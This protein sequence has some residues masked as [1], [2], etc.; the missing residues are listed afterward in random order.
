[1]SKSAK[2]SRRQQ[3]IMELI[4]ERGEV[5]VETLAIALRV[6]PQTIRRDLNHLFEHNLLDR[7]HGGAVLKGSVENLGYGARK[8]LMLEEKTAIA[9]RV[10]ELIPNY[11]SLFINIGTTTERVSEFLVGHQGLLVVTN[12]I[13]VA[14]TLWP[15]QNLQ[16]L[17][18]G[19][20]IRHTDGGIVG[21]STEE[22]IS[23]FKL[24]FAVVG[25]SAID[26]DGEILDYDLREV[27]VAKTIM[28]CAE[29]S[30]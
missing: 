20:T 5:Q 29:I 19:G 18:A 28:R 1:M 16:V 10:A 25:C 3:Q 15:S 9:E 6:T 7:V 8:L 4:R 21:P 11:S 22:F 2:V 14:T 24:D 26:S 30:R 12:N 13:H 17:I 23:S 27:R